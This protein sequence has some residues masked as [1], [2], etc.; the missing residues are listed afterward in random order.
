MQ[1]SPTQPLDINIS[2]PKPQRTFWQEETPSFDDVLDIL[3]PLQH[4]PVISN[5][6]Q[7]ESGDGSS[8]GANIAG[9]AL[10]GGALGALAALFNEIMETETGNNIGGH[11]LSMFTGESTPAVQTAQA[12]LPQE[13]QPHFV[14]ASRHSA[15]NRY[16]SVQ[17]LWA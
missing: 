1:T 14:S 9:G 17:N 13:A 11:L 6:Y 15:I 2:A 5:L 4:I 16:V 3:N 12:E 8:A 10:F 7:A